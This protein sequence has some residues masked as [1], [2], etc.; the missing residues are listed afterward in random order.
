MIPTIWHSGKDRTMGT[1]KRSVVARK[2]GDDGGVN[3]Q[4][5]E[6]FREVKI[7]CMIL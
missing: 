5:T 1:I 7:L 6:E 2:K 4:S 3:R